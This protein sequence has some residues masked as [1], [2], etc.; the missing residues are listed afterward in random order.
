MTPRP[1]FSALAKGQWGSSRALCV[2]L[3][4]DFR[5]IEAF[6]APP[7]D[8]G[9][10]LA[11]NRQIVDATADIAAAYKPNSAFYEARGAE[12]LRD[13]RETI[14]YIHSVAPESLVILDA[15]RADIDSTN[16]G[17]VEY[18]FDYLS[19]DAITV[20]PYLGVD[21]MEPFLKCAGKGI[22]VLCRTS[23]AGAGEFQDL[24]ISEL[25]N[26]R[27]LYERVAERVATTWNRYGNCGLVVGA[28]FPSEL[29][30]VREIATTLPI[31][32]PGVGQQGGD[33]AAAVAAGVD[34]SGGGIFVNVSRSLIFKERTS[35]FAVAARAE[36][37]RLDR[38]IRR[39]LDP[40][41]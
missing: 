9:A 33:L 28:T 31:L 14:R 23:N 15:K 12:G 26:T 25:G 2:G 22:L 20:H 27:P 5:T 37:L 24:P 19:A 18:A 32:I 35:E 1:D 11:F 4:S 30:R 6:F 13:L 10:Q 8:V 34:E 41:T 21:A 17:Y 36:A 38:D 29:A 3:D 39:C 40:T 7:S 16:N